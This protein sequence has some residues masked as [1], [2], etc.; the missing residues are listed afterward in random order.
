MDMFT[1]EPLPMGVIDTR[2]F[3]T[4]EQDRDI[5]ERV[6]LEDGPRAGRNNDPSYIP[7]FGSDDSGQ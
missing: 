3:T 4:S 6:L 1:G 5:M 2:G 7:G